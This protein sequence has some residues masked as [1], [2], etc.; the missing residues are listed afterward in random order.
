MERGPYQAV[1][2][3]DIGYAGGA[4]AKTPL[5][6]IEAAHREC[7]IASHVVWCVARCSEPAHRFHRVRGYSKNDGVAV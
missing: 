4:Q 3:N 6:V 1:S 5:N 7:R 2:I